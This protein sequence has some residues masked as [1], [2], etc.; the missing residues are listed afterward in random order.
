MTETSEVDAH[1]EAS[2][3]RDRDHIVDVDDGCEVLEPGEEP[4]AEWNVD[5][6]VRR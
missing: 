1:S 5:P 6:R 2:L 4:G 3:V